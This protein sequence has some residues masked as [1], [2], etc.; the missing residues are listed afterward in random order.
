MIFV[1]FIDALL[2][3]IIGSMN[4][5][6]RLKEFIVE[7]AEL[8]KCSEIVENNAFLDNLKREI[9]KYQ[10]FQWGNRNK[11]KQIQILRTATD[12]ICNY[13]AVPVFDGT[14]YVIIAKSTNLD[15]TKSKIFLAHEISHCLSDDLQYSVISLIRVISILFPITVFLFSGFTLLLF[16]SSIIGAI[17]FF[18]QIWRETYTEITANNAAIEILEAIDDPMKIKKEETINTLL[19]I[20]QINLSG[21][22]SRMKKISLNEQIRLLKIAMNGRILSFSPV[23]WLHGTLIVLLYALTAYSIIRFNYA[24][25][26]KLNSWIIMMFIIIVQIIIFYFLTIKEKKIK[27]ILSNMTGKK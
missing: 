23:N 8:M 16:I 4:I 21:N 18:A 2:N 3:R 24:I 14:S 10:L 1:I 17:L 25:T 6:N 19:K 15:K 5:Y 27:W 26:Y 22:T 11:Q 12:I 20:K 9:S 13:V 7:N